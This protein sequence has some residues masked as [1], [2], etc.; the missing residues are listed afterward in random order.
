M[1]ETVRWTVVGDLSEWPPET[2]RRVQVGARRI[3][4]FHH[5]G[6]WYALKDVCPHAGV[7]LTGGPLNDG[8]V[9]CPAHGWRFRLSDGELAEPQA[10]N[11]RPGTFSVATYPVRINAGKVE[12][13]L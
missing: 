5:G 3:G 11:A 2:G 13:G 7:A 1:N 4:V 9:R 6:A 12:V 10:V 8:T